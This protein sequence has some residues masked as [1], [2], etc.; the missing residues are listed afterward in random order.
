MSEVKR[1]KNESFEAFF[2]RVKQQ[3]MRSGKVLQV[4]KVQHFSKD[5]SKNVSRKQA[6][7]YAKV[8][9]KTAYL[10]KIGRLPEE[11]IPKRGRR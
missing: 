1:K 5:K 3:W 9:S 7:A 10:R 8:Q 4:R 2:R 11:E 6:V